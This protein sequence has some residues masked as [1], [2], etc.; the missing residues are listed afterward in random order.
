MTYVVIPQALKI[1]I[2]P[3]GN[4][5]VAIFKD[6]ALVSVITMKDLMF[7][8]QILASSTFKHFEIF[9]IVALIYFMLSYPAAKLVEAIERKLNGHSEKSNGRRRVFGFQL[10]RAS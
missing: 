8:G 1:V 10:K 2:P 4:F 7:T 6:S 3:I 9:A 5:F